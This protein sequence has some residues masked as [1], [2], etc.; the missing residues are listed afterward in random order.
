MTH[1]TIHD[2]LY[3][4]HAEL[5]PFRVEGVQLNPA[6]VSYICRVLAI[7][8]ADVEQVAVMLRQASPVVI[9]PADD[10]VVCI[11]RYRRRH[12][13]KPQGGGDAA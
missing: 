10:K 11:A 9:D 4:L 6:Q 12:H 5:A 8:A 1:L 13:A 2:R 7:C 3:L